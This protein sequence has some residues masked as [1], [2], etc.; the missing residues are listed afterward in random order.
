M[1]LT[2]RMLCQKPLLNKTNEIQIENPKDYDLLGFISISI[3]WRDLLTDLL[4]PGSDGIVIVIENECN[5]SFSFQVTG[6]DV[7]YLGR[8]DLHDSE[9]DSMEVN[10]REPVRSFICMLG[11]VVA[12]TRLS[13]T[14]FACSRH[15]CWNLTR[16][17]YS[18]SRTPAFQL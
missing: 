11:C 17:L 8:G 3:Y 4:P 13:T 10:V 14:L 16:S 5:P 1:H 7:T 12:V 18:A 6:P 15:G 2:S 9:F